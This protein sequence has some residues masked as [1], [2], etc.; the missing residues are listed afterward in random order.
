MYNINPDFSCVFSTIPSYYTTQSQRVS[1]TRDVGFKLSFTKLGSV[2]LKG[3]KENIVRLET[4][5]SDSETG[6]NKLSLNLSTHAGL[7]APA[8]TLYIAVTEI[9]LAPVTIAQML[10]KFNMS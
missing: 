4:E 5:T 1:K 3:E 7:G 8:R 2:C 6:I 9:A 10:Y